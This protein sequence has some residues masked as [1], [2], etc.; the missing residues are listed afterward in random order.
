MKEDKEEKKELKT[1]KQKNVYIGVGTTGRGRGSCKG[2]REEVAV[3]LSDHSFKWHNTRSWFRA[4]KWIKVC[5]RCDILRR[6]WIRE[7]WRK[8]EKE[9][10]KKGGGIKKKF[11]EVKK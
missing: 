10:L 1:K 9:G 2:G 8:E 6:R 7:G 11:T 3:C 4:I 5:A